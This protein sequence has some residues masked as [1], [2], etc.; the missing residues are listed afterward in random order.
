MNSD[1]NA[2]IDAAVTALSES[3]SSA[4]SYFHLLRGLH[5][6]GRE[7]PEVLKRF[8]SLFDQAWRA[9]FEGFFAKAGTLLDSTRSTYSLPNLVTLVRR[10]GDADLKQ[11]LPEVEACL[12]DKD[13]P[14]AK[15]KSWRHEAVAHRPQDGRDETFYTNN[16]MNLNDLE[17]ALMQLEEALNHLSWNVLRIHNDTRTE[18]MSLVEEGRSL[19]TS[20][21][22][23]IA[24]EPEGGSGV[25]TQ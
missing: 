23:G 21:A 13:S 7:N 12:S 15:I 1:Q 25:I 2:N 19:F 6:G 10:Y 4:W 18:S 5:E 8:G 22:A 3:L 20:L 9:I 11:L 16:K 14:L 24:S 17:S